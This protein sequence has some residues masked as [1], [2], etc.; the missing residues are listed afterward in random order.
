MSYR[1]PA[2]PK[3]PDGSNMTVGEM[4]PQD[5]RAQMEA[6]NAR[7]MTGATVCPAC[8]TGGFHYTCEDCWTPS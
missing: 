7:F 3:R 6:A 4:S 5:R 2:W 1:T 8:S